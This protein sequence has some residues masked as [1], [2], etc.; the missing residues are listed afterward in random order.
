MP[1]SAF[2][3]AGAPRGRSA[4]RCFVHG[5]LVMSSVFGIL[6]HGIRARGVTLSEN[7]ATNPL[8]RSWRVF[9]DSSLFSWNS[10]SQNL[11][12]TWDSSHTN[13]YYYLP[14]GTILDRFDDFSFSFDLRLSDILGGFSP[15]K[16]STFELSIGLLNILNAVK[17]N[18]YRGSIPNSPN[19]VEFDFFPDTGFGP[20][21]WPSI[22][23]TNGSLNYNGSSDYTIADLPLNVTM[24]ISMAYSASNRTLTTAIL[25]NGTPVVAVAS[26]SLT[27]SFKDF[28]V[29]AFSISSYSD[30]GQGPPAPGSLL[31]HGI[32]DNVQVNVPPPPIQNFTAKIVAGQFQG[33][34]VSRTNWL[35]SLQRSTNFQTWTVISSNNIGTGGPMTLTD[36]LVP[37]R[38]FFRLAAERPF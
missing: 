19:L 22:Y 2:S 37:P 10:T 23:S 31:A 30:A 1:L 20:T 33:S 34:F 9:G 18:Y 7:F 4:F 21:I 28:R 38:Q 3:L 35:Y 13:S 25:T 15:G 27:S 26:V 5:L 12:V 36:S 16:P 11:A 29:A 8:T 14:L 17:T 32:V 6:C 24:Q